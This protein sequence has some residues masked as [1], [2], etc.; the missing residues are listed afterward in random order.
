MNNE[1]SLYQYTDIVMYKIE[2][3][4][5]AGPCVKNGEIKIPQTSFESKF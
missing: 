3:A 5:M 1:V 2:K 4:A